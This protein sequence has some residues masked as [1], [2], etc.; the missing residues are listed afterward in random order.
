MCKPVHEPIQHITAVHY[1]SRLR[2]TATNLRL[3]QTATHFNSR[4]SAATY[5]LSPAAGACVHSVECFERVGRIDNSSI[6]LANL[7][8]LTQDRPEIH[9]MLTGEI[10]KQILCLLGCS[11]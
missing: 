11:I 3:H 2:R 4:P 10:S 6:G 5:G 1:Y 9:E 8:L 7:I